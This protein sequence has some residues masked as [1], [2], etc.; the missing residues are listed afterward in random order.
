MRW[1]WRSPVG[2]WLTAGLTAV[3][4]VVAS[5]AAMPVQAQDRAEYAP[6]G[7][8]FRLPDKWS[9]E[10]GKQKLTLVA[11]NEDGFIQFTV[12]QPGNDASLRAQV[13]QALTTYLSDTVLADPGDTTT[14]SGMQ[15][16]RV[17]GTGS[18]DATVVQ[19]VAVTVT[20]G[21][22]VLIL[23]YASDDSFAAHSPIFE[24]L[25]KSLKRR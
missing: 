25:I 6:G 3:A 15:G 10:T 24:A 23:A 20:A 2:Q 16:F 4:M 12:L 21:K 11:P 14:I 13:A 19:F 17:S 5:L 1:G 7:L 22:P 18:S 9:V 8:E